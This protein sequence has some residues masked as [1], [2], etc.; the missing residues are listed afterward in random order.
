MEVPGWGQIKAWR[1]SCL[2]GQLLNR[3]GWGLL[4]VRQDGGT[5]A[6]T[7]PGGSHRRT[8]R[9]WVSLGG[10]LRHLKPHPQ[11]SPRAR[12]GP[13]SGMSGGL[14]TSAVSAPHGGPGSGWRGRGQTGGNTGSNS[15]SL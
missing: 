11:V 10:A 3:E 7:F 4:V 9:A 8:V 13:E 2:A 14:E 6:S 1:P 12:N 5:S 15:P